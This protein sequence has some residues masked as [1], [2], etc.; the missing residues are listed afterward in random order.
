MRV[1]VILVLAS[2]TFQ[3]AGSYQPQQIQPGYWD[4]TS[5]PEMG[6]VTYYA[7]GMMDYVANYREQHGQLPPCDDCVGSVAL[8]RAGDIGRKVWLQLPGTDVVYGPFL[9]VDCART[10]D[11]PDLLDRD[12]VVD[13]SFEVGQ[14]WGLTGP[15][16]GVIVW[17][18]PAEA[19]APA[20]TVAPTRLYIDPGQVLIMT[21]TPPSLGT[22]GKAATRA[23]VPRPQPHP[24]SALGYWPVITTPTPSGPGAVGQEVSPL[25]SVPSEQ[26]GRLIEVALGRPGSV[27]L[28]AAR[29][30]I[31]TSAARPPGPQASATLAYAATYTPSVVQKGRGAAIEPPAFATVAPD[32][33]SAASSLLERM[34]EAVLDFL[35]R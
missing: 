6:L 35:E 19:S 10:E 22:L 20:P 15:M 14:A 28:A 18:D 13:V 1:F 16:D 2:V 12:W 29:P 3:L 26:A 27:L 8:L 31:L 9:V 11:I 32:R 7:P 34:W 21:P 5:L 24:V 30:I 33:A 25:G 4:R 17:P 23:P